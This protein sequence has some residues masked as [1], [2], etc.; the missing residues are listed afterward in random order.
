MTAIATTATTMATRRNKSPP[1]KPERYTREGRLCYSADLL[2]PRLPVGD[3]DCRQNV[4]L[5]GSGNRQ[6]ATRIQKIEQLCLAL[7]PGRPIGRAAVVVV[8]EVGLEEVHRVG[9]KL[10]IGAGL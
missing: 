9:R 10:V 5:A 4:D 2:E 3:L 7:L 1:R 6:G 8:A